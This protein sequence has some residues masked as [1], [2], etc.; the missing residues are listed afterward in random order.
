MDGQ[1]PLPKDHLQVLRQGS[2]YYW[3]AGGTYPAARIRISEHKGSLH[4]GG[5]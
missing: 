1:T 2:Q 4:L 3:V 5:G